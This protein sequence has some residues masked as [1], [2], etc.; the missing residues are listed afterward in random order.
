MQY[1]RELDGLRAIAVIPVVLLHAGFKLFSGGFVGVDVFFVISGYLITS[2]ISE[3][4]RNG[5]FTLAGFYE[6]RARRI[7]PALL[8]MLLVCVPLAWLCSLPQDTSF[9]SQS[10]LAVLGFVS[11]VFFS[12]TTG[13]FGVGSTLDPLIHTW[14]L[15]VEEQYYILFPALLLLLRRL[16]PRTTGAALGVIAACSLMAAQYYASTDPQFD[17]YGLPTRGWEILAGALTAFYSRRPEGIRAAQ[18]NLEQGRVRVTLRELGSLIGIASIAGSMFFFDDG[19]PSPSVYSLIP[20]LGAVLVIMY[21]H[22]TTLIGKV[23]GVRLLVA[24]GS[25]SYSLYL[26][27]QPV[28]AF[29]RQ[30]LL[31]E[32]ELPT[33][34]VL[35]LM[36]LALSYASWRFIEQ[37]FRNRN[38]LSRA[39]LFTVSGSATV[40]LL[41]I[42]VSGW[43]TNG[44]PTR[45]GKTQNINQALVKAAGVERSRVVRGDIC[46]FNNLTRI[47]IDRFLNQWN[48]KDDGA[49]AYLQR[50]PVIIAGDSHSADKVIAL[51]LNGLLPLQI[52]GAGCSIIP[53]R[54]SSDCQRIYQKLYDVTAN[55]PY[56]QYLVLA[57]SFSESE[58]T[59]DSIQDAVA[60]WKR[61][62]KKLVWFTSMPTFYQFAAH[63]QRGQPARIDFRISDLSRGEAI[64]RILNDSGIHIVDTK[65]IFCSINDCSY[66]SKEGCV[67]MVNDSH[68]SLWGAKLFGRALLDTEPLFS[69]W[70]RAT[71]AVRIPRDL[72]KCHEPVV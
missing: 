11:N 53:R 65:R 7:L 13:Y 48:C 27:H 21:A 28:L 67:L 25:V 22:E 29:A 31:A 51:K 23:L 54:M 62:N 56:Y 38:T 39:R 49:F 70:A 10:V 68:L 64:S 52:G 55:D 35:L 36:T 71:T 1:R 18:R 69:Q 12:H 20:V 40:C 24:I 72:G 33:V 15:A 66:V 19:T 37:P 60:Y 57:H 50:I 5:S 2:I 26:I 47:G 30:R 16:N 3:E 6:R 42:A 44:F 63:L 17:F 59:P 9:F 58:L 8:A 43:R 14:S 34:A 61:Y 46:Q 32:P 4:T 45:F 41:V